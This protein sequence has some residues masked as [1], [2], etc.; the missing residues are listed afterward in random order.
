VSV[1]A[2]ERWPAVFPLEGERKGEWEGAAN[3]EQNSKESDISE[4]QDEQASGAHTQTMRSSESILQGVQSTGPPSTLATYSQ[5]KD[6][7]SKARRAGPP[8]NERVRALH[9]PSLVPNIW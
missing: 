4:S 3:A 1:S 5:T 9:S 6:C 8:M 7:I 2:R